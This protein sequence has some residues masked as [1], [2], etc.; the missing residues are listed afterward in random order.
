M[1]N[2]KKYKTLILLTTENTFNINFYKNENK[3]KS[4]FLEKNPVYINYLQNKRSKILRDF[5]FLHSIFLLL[6]HFNSLFYKSE[7]EFKIRQ[8]PIF[9]FLLDESYDSFFI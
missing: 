4:N 8:N 9:F 7:L 2:C 3:I 6:L 1:F 5:L